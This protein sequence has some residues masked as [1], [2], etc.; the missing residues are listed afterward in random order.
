MKRKLLV[1]MLSS[2][3]AVT[4]LAGAVPSYAAGGSGD[5]VTEKVL[6]KSN[7]G[8]PVLGFDG[9]GNTLYGGDPAALVDGDTVYLYVGHDNSSGDSYVMPDWQCYSTKDMKNFKYEG[10]ILKCKDVPWA[11]STSAW[12]SQVV[13][14]KDKYYLY[15]C[16]E[17]KTSKYGKCVGVAV[18]DSPTG[19]FKAENKPIV[20]DSDT[21]FINPGRG[22]AGWEDIDPTA[23]V[24]TVD[25]VEHRYLAWGNTN[26]YIAELNEDMVSIKDR[27]GD[28]VVSFKSGDIERQTIKGMPNGWYFAEAPWLYRRQDANGNYYGKYYLFYAMYWR[29][30]MA[31][32][33]SDDIWADEWDY[34]GLIMEPTATSNT[35]HM[36]VIDFKGKTYFVY[37]NGSLPWGSGF[38]RVVCIQELH[39]DKDG[40]IE[41]LQENS[42]GLTGT[43]STIADSKGALV[44]HRTYH[45]STSDSAYPYTKVA[46]STAEGAVTDDS[47]WEI[48]K[49]KADE[50]NDAYVS[51]E[52]YNKP[53]IW[54]QVDDDKTVSMGQDY[55]KASSDGYTVDSKR[56]TFRTLNGFDKSVKNGTTFES[57][58][59]PGY[60]LTSK[61]GKLTVEK[62]PDA[63]DCTFTI[64]AETAND[65]SSMIVRKSDR[66]YEVG[67]KLA[68]DDLRLTVVDEYD[69][70]EIVY[71]GADGLTVD[72]SAVNMKKA[73][74]YELKVEYKGQSGT[75]QIR[76]LDR[77]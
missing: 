18:S 3:M 12:A 9:E 53:G 13:K 25:G 63:A 5:V 26:H 36:A 67:D 30:Q 35:N 54:L 68:T 37:H 77:N 39:F 29:E 62:E 57:V 19:P 27:N 24:E 6:N 76:V 65:L 70:T 56:M 55:Q 60:Y 4:A 74:T 1:L 17:E 51:I 49:G 72:A 47:M 50:D 2:A 23:W 71:S 44:K 32:A 59:Y 48:E 40:K 16:A 8:N 11:D 33:T 69:N 43:A 21:P 14:Y 58:A 66:T 45:N 34:G 7:T 61:G 31:Y 10:E 46:V 52:S 22:G 64:S 42:I 41:Y 20:Y 28:G 73:G 15:F 75:V 38:R